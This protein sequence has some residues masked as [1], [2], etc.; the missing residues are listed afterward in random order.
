MSDTVLSVCI[1]VA[2]SCFALLDW[3]LPSRY[4]VVVV[5]AGGYKEKQNL[6]VA[7]REKK[8]SGFRKFSGV[9]LI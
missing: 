6:N 4:R 5:V 2:L 9:N 3:I 8:V 1:V 7:L